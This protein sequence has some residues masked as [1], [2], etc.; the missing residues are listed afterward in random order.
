MNRSD[1]TGDDHASPA[2]AERLAAENDHLKVQVAVLAVMEK[3]F[4]A[5]LYGIGDAVI[6][7][8][9]RG[10]VQQMNP[11]AETL[12]GWSEAE[13][14][15]KAVRDVFRIVDEGSRIE[16]DSPVEQAIREGSIVDLAN[17]TLLIGRDGKEHATAGSASPVRDGAGA[18]AGVVLI[19]RD[20]S[21]ERSA[22]E[23]L[24]D[25]ERIQ[26]DIL[27]STLSGY[28]D[29]NL[30][31]GTEYLSPT[32]KKMF[33]YEDHELPNAPETWQKL[34]FAEDLPGVLE[35]FDRHVRSRGSE[36][37]YNEIRYRHRNGSA[38]WVICTGRVIE[39]APDGSPVRMV[40]CHV[41]ITGRKRTEARLKKALEDL[42]L[43]NRELE[44]F[45]YVASH[46]LQEPLRKISAFG[47]LLVQECGA[48][49]SADG[50]EYLDHIMGA[51]RRMQA[52]INDLLQLSRVA[53]R[54]KAFT[55]V[56]LNQTLREVLEDLGA[57]LK[58]SGG[59]V[60]VEPLPALDADAIQMRQLFQNLI[61]N[62]LKFRKAG[63]APTVVVRAP[64]VDEKANRAVICVEDHG[65]GF[66]S[67]FDERIFGLFQR[68][69][70]RM[71]YEGT[72][73]GLAIC[74]RIA[75]RHGGRITAEGRLGDGAT[76]RLELPMKQAN[77]K[78]GNAT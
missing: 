53:T 55:P 35:T 49:V 1:N 71:E 17:P 24:R 38:V 8:D 13:A 11:V 33:G 6:V 58:E 74:R 32:F 40:G 3:R 65:I 76:F 2:S 41:D 39:W 47:G 61:A 52:L 67:R 7:T 72:G 20:V 12:A 56:D 21:A 57:R 5:I 23:R 77:Q 14:A 63:E 44:E 60:T 73:I 62:A 4:R 43:S 75:E 64:E 69:H 45:A 50:R 29:W 36:P 59:T 22:I 48:A 34:I 78:E 42:Q 9:L 31:A 51:V 30:A 15:G 54:A 37:F 68:L 66:E 46:D 26:G 10:R 18:M 16:V 25:S 70:G 27:E 19:F 28:W